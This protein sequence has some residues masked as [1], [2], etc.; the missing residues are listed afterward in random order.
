MHRGEYSEPTAGN[1]AALDCKSVPLRDAGARGERF[2][3]RIDS[4][5]TPEEPAFAA[6]GGCVP[7]EMANVV[8]P[9]S[10]AWVSG[11]NV[12]LFAAPTFWATRWWLGWRDAFLLWGALGVLALVIET[13]AIITGF[14]YGHFGYSG[15]LGF[16]LF[17]LTPWTVFLAWTP[18]V[19]AA[20]AI[21]RR[22]FEAKPLAV[23]YQLVASILRIVLTAVLLVVFDLVLDPGAV[24]IGFWRY[25]GG[26][27]FYGVPVSNFVGWLFSGAIAGVVLETF[28]LIK[29]PLLPAPAQMISST[30]FIVAFWTFIAFFSGMY[31]PL[32]IGIVVIALLAAF[33][34]KYHYAFDD[35]I[36]YCDES[37]VPTGTSR[38]LAAHDGDTKRHLAFSIFL[39]NDKGEL[40]L[41][42]RALTKK[43]WPGVWSNSC[44]G[45]VMLH[46][47][48]ESAA[49]RRLKYELGM[50]VEKLH[51]ILP[52]FRYRAEKDGVVENEICPVFVGFAS[53]L[54][55]PNPA[56]VND[57]KWVDWE[58]F[59]VEVADPANGYS[60]WAR[61]EVELLVKGG[62]LDR[63]RIRSLGSL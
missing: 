22:L 49:R 32:A 57:V 47:S 14:P 27:V 34:S 60:P 56:E 35:M 55:R 7:G 21:A 26:G 52:D 37:G 24:K 10:L 16:R 28:T 46:E 59:V 19:L 40:L 23:S 11:I 6:E 54:P 1:A 48:T 45:H 8:I 2:N 62:S 15:L 13:S 61:E 25:E 44:C 20:Y 50:R 3:V 41:Q 4:T 5:S 17:G 12:I 51:L 42:Q 29:K 38:K 30:F 53:A 58:Q 18:L 43:T 9:P 31:W 39:F 63:S 33:Y 36:V